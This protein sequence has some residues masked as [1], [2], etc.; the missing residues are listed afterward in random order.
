MLSPPL[1]R[2]TEPEALNSVQLQSP[3]FSLSLLLV[4][5]LKLKGRGFVLSVEARGNEWTRA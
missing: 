2:R 5:R 4:G 1:G 3:W